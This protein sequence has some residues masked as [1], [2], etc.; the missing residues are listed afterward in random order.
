LRSTLFGLMLNGAQAWQ[1][2]RL[3]R[4]VG[5]TGP[6]NYQQRTTTPTNIVNHNII[7]ENASDNNILRR[8]CTTPPPFDIVLDAL[9]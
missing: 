5:S 8:T 1:A 6:E 7:L 3:K 4:R 9:S 2:H